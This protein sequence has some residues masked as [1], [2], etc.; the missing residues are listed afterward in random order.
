MSSPV[1]EIKERL[2]I[3]EVIGEY[4]PLKKAGA[5]H[6]ARCPF[7]NEKT[8][9]FTV[10]E[11]KQFFHCFGCGKGGDIFTFIQE[12]EG[13]EF[14]EA[15]RILARKANVLLRPTMPQEHNER[16][17]LFD[18]LQLT[19]SFFHATLNAAPD[20]RSA[21]DYLVHR[22]VSEEII[23][24]FTVGYSLPQW[25][26]LVKFL[27][28]RGIAE[29][30][31]ERAGLVIR[32]PKTAGMYDRFRGRVMFP[33]HDHHGQVV[34]FGA[35]TLDPKQKEA[36]YVNSPQTMLYNKSAV[37]YGL[38]FA[39]KFIQ[40]MDAVVIVEGYMDVLA[41]HQAKFRNVVAA[42]GTAL[43]QEQ[44]RLLQRYSHN[45]IL[46]F[47]ADR[48]G[49]AAA[50]RGMQIAVTEGMNI[51][52]LVLP[53]G[54]DPDDVVRDN[55]ET[56]RN[57]ALVAPSFMEYAFQTILEPLDLRNVIQKKRAAAELFPMIALF[58]DKIEQTHYLQLLADKLD[59]DAAILMERLHTLRP[60][61]LRRLQ[62][63]HVAQTHPQTQK[64]H[65]PSRDE[66][67]GS[68]LLAYFLREPKHFSFVIT[69]VQ[70]DMIVGEQQTHLYKI[71]E[72]LYNRD[73]FLDP[74]KVVQENPTL[75][76]FLQEIEL[77]GEESLADFTDANIHK[78]ILNILR[79][80]ELRWID[81]TTRLL[82][83]DL[84]TAESAQD[85]QRVHDLTLRLQQLLERRKFV[86]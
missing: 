69:R 34:G 32:S 76:T 81:R 28:Q 75:R 8:P 14:P 25:D 51:K 16:T 39:K 27:Q 80:L 3:V 83:K 30:T 60:S 5:N 55:P 23:N 21:R 2:N 49:L 86:E 11:P 46:A 74:T 19:A 15:L 6:K 10:S 66:T 62:K 20:G 85:E 29:Q 52:V 59:V 38:P 7:H 70:E 73:G 26:S 40:K 71:C 17:R 24:Q 36:K 65:L 13:V 63:E 4:V 12:M 56:F 79:I 43:T 33:I 47:D 37:L 9:S 67:L 41:L 31:M 57:L 64:S 61:S 58:P 82:Q 84:Q 54:Q 1:E 18:C 42:S 45:V 78:E 77:L 44:V 35:R 72:N 50:W 22:G 68:L 48:A 53:R